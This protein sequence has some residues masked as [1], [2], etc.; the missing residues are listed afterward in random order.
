MK[1]P[2]KMDD[3]GTHIHT[4]KPG[5]SEKNPTSEASFVCREVSSLV[6]D[7]IQAE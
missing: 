6:N 2:I 4:K 5:K 1:N 3:L 7:T